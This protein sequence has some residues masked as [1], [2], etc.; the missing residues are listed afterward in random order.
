MLNQ[1][2][3]SNHRLKLRNLLPTESFMVITAN[4]LL[5]KKSDEAYPFSQDSN[6][7]YLTGL[8]IPEAWL[9]MDKHDTWLVL[10]ARSNCQDLFEGQYNFDQISQISGIN[11]IL[12]YQQGLELLKDLGHKFKKIGLM[13]VNRSYDQ[14]SGF[15]L[16]P[17]NFNLQKII[18]SLQLSVNKFQLDN[19]LAS[20]R[21][22]KSQKEVTMIEKA[23]NITEEAFL[24]INQ[25]LQD[26]KNENQLQ[27]DIN[28]VFYRQASH[29]AFNPIIAGGSR[30][31]LPHYTTNNKIIKQNDLVIVDIGAE[32][33]HYAAD[34]SRTFSIGSIKGFKKNI[35][36]TVLEIHDQA[37]DMLKPGLSY[38]DLEQK[39]FDLIFQAL[40]R[41]KILTNN[42]KS[43]VKN[44]YPHSVSHFLGLDVHDV[45][46]YNQ[47]LKPGMVIT[48]EPGLYLEKNGFG[49]RIED[50]V[51]ITANACR[52]LSHY[53]YNLGQ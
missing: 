35:Y 34:L 31:I 51:L 41:L 40:I 21:Q 6:F 2:F 11:H 5:Q 20:L 26:Y 48:I 17:A 23:I 43:L 53:P 50:D 15:W 30:S 39:V 36:Q 19:L 52:L 24:K 10:A 28:D 14:Q 49:V 45:G 7:W 33:Y 9:I 4:A 16:N 12:N 25:N 3:F 1:T 8:D 42:D 32:Y 29:H 47:T 13:E 37:I 46:D 27:A 44:Y 38:V 18:A 22:I